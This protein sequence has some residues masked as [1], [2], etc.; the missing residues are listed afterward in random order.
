LELTLPRLFEAPSMPVISCEA[1]Q[2]VS[3]ARS[4]GHS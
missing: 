2:C 3:R 4:I 1:L